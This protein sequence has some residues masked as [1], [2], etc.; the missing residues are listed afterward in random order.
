MTRLIRGLGSSKLYAKK[1]FY[2]TLTTYLTMHPDTSI[3]TILVTMDT[4]LHPVNSN[5]KS[6]M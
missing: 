6:V 5:A 3:D 4:E 1:G 2:S